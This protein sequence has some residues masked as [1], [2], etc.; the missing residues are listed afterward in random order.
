MNTPSRF[1]YKS[2]IYCPEL[3]IKLKEAL[4]MVSLII[5]L[6]LPT[7]ASAQE[8]LQV[9]V[10]KIGGNVTAN[11]ECP[12]TTT[13][14][15]EKSYSE[16][17]RSILYVAKKGAAFKNLKA[18]I[19]KATKLNPSATSPIIIKIA[20]GVY[21]LNEVIQIPDNVS[22]VG[23]GRGITTIET[24]V[25]QVIFL[26]SANSLKNLSI[27]W[28]PTSSDNILIFGSDIDNLTLE[29]LDIELSTT[30]GGTNFIYLENT[31]GK[32]R[33][34]YLSGSGISVAGIS[35]REANSNLQMD[36]LKIEITT[37]SGFTIAVDSGAEAELSNSS[38][39]LTVLEDAVSV[40]TALRIGDTGTKF[41]ANNVNSSV[42][43]LGT[44]IC[45]NLYVTSTTDVIISNSRLYCTGPTTGTVVVSEAGEVDINHSVIIGDTGQGL[46]ISND[47]STLR[48]THS[49]LNG[50][51]TTSSG[52]IT[53]A[54]V[55]D[56]NFAFYQTSCP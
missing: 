16:G 30:G 12:A 37:G 41:T 23:S 4:K 26:G 29:D 27:D 38:I 40:P 44:T 35:I 11:K 45:S 47:T 34:V 18:A 5:G 21:S 42:T 36:G 1:N 50:G 19:T 46:M 52:T 7:I 3:C 17:R 32:I 28:Q 6:A 55:T 8:A 25:A 31:V 9:C 15:R 2:E 10:S 43:S 53:C 51:S 20:P 22:I 56:E 39:K 49:Q 14:L 13:R 54:A 48:T 33:N 24:S